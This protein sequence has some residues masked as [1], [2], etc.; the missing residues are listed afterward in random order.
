MNEIRLRHDGPVARILID[1][2]ARRNAISRAMWRA[3]PALVAQAIGAAATRVLTVQS[4]VDGY[5]CAGADIAEFESTYRDPEESRRANAEIQA[6]V[7]ALA[8]VPVPTLALIDGACVGGGVSLA[9]ACDIRLASDR[10]SFAVTPAR[11][12]LSYHPDDI[13][14][15][16]TACG[17]PGAAE[18]L[19]TGKPWPAARA[20][21]SGLVNQAL[22]REGFEAACAGMTAAIAGNSLDALRAMKEGLR[23]IQGGDVDALAQSAGRFEALFD[24]RDFR[25]GRDAFLQ[26]RAAVFPSHFSSHIDAEL[27]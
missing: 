17:H 26:K 3:L 25:E 27:P 20:R 11:L 7:R 4:S 13:A 23:A 24:G 21:E 19:F 10:A 12:G 16:A 2:P 15:L 5:F 1:N 6:A 9:L 14:R 18:L 8:A 22:A